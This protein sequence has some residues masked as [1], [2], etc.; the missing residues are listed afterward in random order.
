TARVTNITDTGNDA[1]VD[2]TAGAGS[3]K[4]GTGGGASGGDGSIETIAST[5]NATKATSGGIFVNSLGGTG[6]GSGP[7]NFNTVSA[8]TAGN[9]ELRAVTA[10]TLTNIDA[11][12]GTIQ[13]TVTGASLSAVAVD[14]GTN[15]QID[16]ATVTSGNIALGLVNAGTGTVNV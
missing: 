12:N 9:V 3:L 13:A 11:A 4:A 8:Q 14:T 1:L 2:V 10:R 7:V 6:A 16:L 15:N 5:G